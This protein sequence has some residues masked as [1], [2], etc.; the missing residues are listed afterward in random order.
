MTFPAFAVV[1]AIP[2]L[3]EIVPSICCVSAAVFE[4]ALIVAI[5]P[6]F[7]VIARVAGNVT[8]V[9][10]LWISVPDPLN[11][12]PFVRAPRRASASTL[13]VPE[14]I[15]MPPP[16]V[17]AEVFS[18]SVPPPLRTMP[19]GLVLSWTSAFIVSWFALM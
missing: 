10:L 14:L 9:A 16:N 4:L 13:S 7:K 11:V 15:V 6:L 2:P 5:A 3:P 18:A 1:V 19:P 17:F 8:E 12:I